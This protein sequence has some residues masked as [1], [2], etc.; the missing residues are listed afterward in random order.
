MEQH[1]AEATK[2]L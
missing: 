2:Q 1:L